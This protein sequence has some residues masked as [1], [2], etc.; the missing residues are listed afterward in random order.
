MCWKNIKS[1]STFIR[2]DSAVSTVVAVALLLGILAIVLTNFRVHFV[3]QWQEDAESAHM[4][5]VCEDMSRLKANMD[6]LS[7]GLAINP[8][9]SAA[10]NTPIR[11]GGGEV[12]VFNRMR[13]GGTLTMNPAGSRMSA[14]VT[15]NNSTTAPI[16]G[17]GSLP[18]GAISYRS[19]NYR[20]IDQLYSYENGALIIA[21]KNRSLMRLPPAI[22]L[23]PEPYDFLCLSVS[24]ICL[25]GDGEALS[26]SGVEDLRL[27]SE[28]KSSL[29]DSTGLESILNITSISLTIFTDYPEAWENYLNNTADEEMLH[30]G[31]DYNLSSNSSEVTF[32]LHPVDKD[33]RVKVY[34]SDIKVDLMKR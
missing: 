20:Y 16:P 15:Y 13:S 25:E 7:T 10:L 1:G 31:T 21:Q 11:M 19:N 32:N 9:L 8:D 14:V 18:C 5:E 34:K 23:E 17:N 22:F 33:L 27:K 6:F 12:S 28:S 4:M 3:P 26:S 29:Y 24:A 2:S 30:W